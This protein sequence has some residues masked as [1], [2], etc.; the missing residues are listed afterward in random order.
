MTAMGFWQDLRD[1]RTVERL[2]AESGSAA[3]A[4][5]EEI[6]ARRG[7]RARTLDALA[8]LRSERG[9]VDAALAAAEEAGGSLMFGAGRILRAEI[10][11][12][13]ERKDEARVLLAEARAAEP[14]N[15]AAE[16]FLRVL[17]IGDALAAGQA[18]DLGVLPPG[19]IWCS[20]VL[21]RLLLA[22]ETRLAAQVERG[23]ARPELHRARAHLFRPRLEPERFRRFW[24]EGLVSGGRGRRQSV[25]A[26]LRS[27]DLEKAA[28]LLASG[29]EDSP[30]Q[31]KSCLTDE[32]RLLAIEIAFA[33]GRFDEAARIHA[34]WM[35]H[36]GER[37]D[38]YPAALAAYALLAEGKPARAREVLAPPLECPGRKAEIRHLASLVEIQ[39]GALP[40]AAAL[41]RLA[42]IDDDISMVNLAGEEAKYLGAV[43]GR[44]STAD[45]K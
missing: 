28:S 5:L 7:P 30:E 24:L 37:A 31:G 45:S 35:K 13:A 25:R 22:L 3:I 38:P 20:V 43:D 6:R 34:N 40:R 2:A 29:G 10:L 14:G 1:S 4:Q 15:I 33:A 12:D 19:A 11:C 44:R 21:S 17:E 36:G 41:I 42:V 8:R 27:G 16:G 9:E 39:E 18:P 32:E 23:G 26:A